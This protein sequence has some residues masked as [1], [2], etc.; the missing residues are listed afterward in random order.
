MSLRVLNNA[1]SVLATIKQVAQ[2]APASDSGLQDG[3]SMHQATLI[4][5]W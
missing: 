3:V 4:S 5:Q 1:C 2:G